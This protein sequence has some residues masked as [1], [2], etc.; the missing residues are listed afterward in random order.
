MHLHEQQD[1][2]LE[3]EQKSLIIYHD[4]KKPLFQELDKKLNGKLKEM[5]G[6]RYKT[7][8]TLGLIAAPS[9][10]ILPEDTF[11]SAKKQEK[12]FRQ[13]VGDLENDALL[14]VD[15]FPA[16]NAK[17]VMEQT[18]MVA[19]R[20]ER[21]KPTTKDE[22]GER[23]IH[24]HAK[25]ADT[26]EINRGIILGEA[27][28]NTRDLVNTPYNHL[29][30]EKLAEYVEKFKQ[31]DNVKLEILEKED[32]EKLGMGAFL[33]VNAGSKDP[34]KLIHLEYTGAEGE[35]EK[36]GLVGKGIMYDTGGYSLKSVTSMPSMKMD[37]GGAATVLGAFE[38]V[39]RSGIKKNVSVTIAATDNKI[40]D[41]A[42]V[43]DDIITSA[44]GK[45]IEIIS[46]DAEGRLTLA[47]A[48]WYAQKREARRL[49]DVAT[50][51][52]AVVGALGKHHTGAFS[53]NDDFFTE[54]QKAAE[55]TKEG[56]W[57]LPVCAG[58]HEDLKSKVADMKNSGG[59]VGAGASIAG[60]FL[61]KFVDDD[62]PWIHLDIAGTAYEKETGAKGAM[63]RTIARH[64]GV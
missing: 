16:D 56:L 44:A 3:S 37:M 22:N 36:T 17:D 29:N 38:A 32:C 48:L 13:A 31:Y 45:T 9:V 27:V 11:E 39:V 12:A 58:H 53:N 61:E 18:L 49:I 51:T 43:P 8:A 20:F 1:F 40:G 19:Y 33:A 15:T 62:T 60:A 50:L 7:V 6:K 63:V 24:Y 30:A 35:K 25:D 14:L 54:F 46:T 41:D 5:A 59:R 55:E 21:F 2:H 52:G 57:R 23:T 34:L 10:H 64:L 47:D 4:E 28:N 42:H 26:N